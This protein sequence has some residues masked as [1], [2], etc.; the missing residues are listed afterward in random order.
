M[1]VKAILR[2]ARAEIESRDMHLARCKRYDRFEFIRFSDDD[3]GD[4]TMVKNIE[5][6]SVVQVKFEWL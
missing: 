2:F 3:G 4:I 5:S 1:P 6:G